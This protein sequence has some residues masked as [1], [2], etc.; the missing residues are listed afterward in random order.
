MSVKVSAT[1]KSSAASPEEL[2]S[3]VLSTPLG[4]VALAGTAS[5]YN[6]LLS[7][8]LKSAVAKSLNGADCVPV[9]VDTAN[10]PV[11]VEDKSVT[12]GERTVDTI[13]TWQDGTVKGS[14]I[15]QIRFALSERH[16]PYL[17]FAPGETVTLH[18]KLEGELTQQW[19]ERP[20]AKN[21]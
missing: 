17:T 18:G 10:N 21:R 1:T 6:H 11:R 4:Q 19:L 8:K 16:L 12:R 15:D 13:K 7:D 14:A 5:L 3:A 9:P 2:G 20:R